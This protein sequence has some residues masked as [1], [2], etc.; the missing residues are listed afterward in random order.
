MCSSDLTW[1]P[2]LGVSGILAIQALVSVSIIVYFARKQDLHWL[3]TLIAPIIAAI[4]QAYAVY[5]LMKFRGDLSAAAGVPFI[6]YLWLWPIAV[7]VVGIAIA[8]VIRTSDPG[9]YAGIGRYLHE[10]A[11]AA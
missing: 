1:S 5:L 3:K 10:D 8:L 6:D 4:T 11:P 7:F 2:L 9:K